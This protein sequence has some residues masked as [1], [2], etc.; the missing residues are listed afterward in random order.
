MIIERIYKEDKK[1]VEQC[2]RILVEFLD[3]EGKYD[4][5]YLKRDKL[6]SFSNDLEEENNIL[7]VVREDEKVYG[8]LFGHTNKNKSFKEKVAN[9]SYI[10]I[11]K[12]HRNQKYATKLIQ[13]YIDILKEKNINIIDVKCFENNSIA[14]KLYKKIGFNPLWINLRKE[15]KYNND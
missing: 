3:E 1:L 12:L 11:D 14:M 15:I 9:L 6:N 2:D 8:F 4:A 5:N 10:Y 7:L 13:Y